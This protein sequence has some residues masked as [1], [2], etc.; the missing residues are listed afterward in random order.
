MDDNIAINLTK[1]KFVPETEFAN[2]EFCGKQCPF[3]NNNKCDLYREDL[4][5]FSITRFPHTG[6]YY[7]CLKCIND[8]IPNSNDQ[9]LDL[10]KETNRLLKYIINH[11]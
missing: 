6:Y 9:V 8:V 5:E 3:F 11:M 7:R 2:L 10:L 1:R 4:N